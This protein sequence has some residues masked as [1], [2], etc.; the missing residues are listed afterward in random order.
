MFVNRL[1]ELTRLERWW[2]ARGGLAIVWGRRR[3]GKTA[4]L[5]QFAS[6]RRALFHTGAGRPARTELELISRQASRI[7]AEASRRD[8]VSRPYTDWDDV[9]D[10]LADASPSQ[11]LLVVLDEFPELVST[12]PELPGVLRAFLD[13]AD[14]ATQVRVVVCGSAVRYMQA[15]QEE[16]RPLY[17]RASLV[18]D[19]HPFS[20]SE[21]ALLL[22]DLDP[23]TRAAVYGLV[24]GVPLYLSWW[25][26]SASI[27]DNV[28]ELAGAPGARLLTEGELVLATE[29]ES[30]EYPSAVLHAIANG[31]TKHNQIRGA[32]GAEPTRTIERLIEL[33]LIER[34]QPVTD[35]GRTRRR[36]YR[37]RDNFLAFYLGVLTRYR[38]EIE[39]GLGPTILPV[40]MD[41]LDDHLG[42]AWESAFR[43]HVVGLAATGALGD[44]IVA[45][46]PWWSTDSSAEIDAVALSGRGRVPTCVGEAKWSR[47]V[48]GNRT[49]FELR[50][51]AERVP[52]MV[53]DPLTIVAGREWVDGLPDGA[54]GVTSADIFA[55]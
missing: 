20:P 42:P 34:L 8:L 4:L 9:L 37:I 1:A 10:H 46:G 29:V 16:R 25:D 33:R 27:A 30:G 31:A 12:S 6:G 2:D 50:R 17:G 19:V 28:A 47:R 41:S 49:A 14:G 22:P 13:R 18:L 11:P 43:A 7:T 45:V 21:S 26:Q 38:G 51:R 55:G 36:T 40:I 23:T 32:V 44:D 39:A 24:G 35:I 53:D 5:R 54:L 52:G 3:V 15:V 48:D